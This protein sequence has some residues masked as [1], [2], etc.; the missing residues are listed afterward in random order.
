METYQKENITNCPRALMREYEYQNKHC[1][2]IG[3]LGFTGPVLRYYIV[4][5]VPPA[6]S[7]IN[8][9]IKKNQDWRIA[10][11]T[12]ETLLEWGI[13]PRCEYSVIVLYDKKY[14]NLYKCARC[15]QH[16]V[17]GDFLTMDELQQQFADLV[18]LE[19]QVF[20]HKIVLCAEAKRRGPGAVASLSNY[21]RYTKQ[22][23]NRL[24]QLHDLPDYLKDPT[25]QIGVYWAAL[26]LASDGDDVNMENFMAWIEEAIVNEWSLKEF[27]EYHGIATDRRQPV[28]DGV[29]ELVRAGEYQWKDA[30][31]K[32]Y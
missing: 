32:V 11:P 8:S 29:A 15:G 21:R 16:G 19:F 12:N 31:V 14:D 6:V 22:T 28:F 30:E 10:M 26:K 1:V 3:R 24:A 2:R 7:P 17:A 9:S 13:C 4:R 27:K 23:I 18:E 20:L 25:L 5:V